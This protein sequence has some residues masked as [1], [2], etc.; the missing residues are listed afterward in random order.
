MKWFNR[1]ISV[2]G[3]I[4]I[5]CSCSSTYRFTVEIRK[6]AEITFPSDVNNV[7][8]VNNAAA[9]SPEES[10][11]CKMM[12]NRVK[13]FKLSK[14]S[15]IWSAVEALA[16][17]IDES[18]FFDKTLVYNFPI[19]KDKEYLTVKPIPQNEIKS[20]VN[21]AGTETLLSVERMLFI[22]KQN[23]NEVTSSYVLTDFEV[24]VSATYSIY[25]PSKS[26]AM[27]TFTIQD[28]L[29]FSDFVYGDS[30][31][32]FKEMGEFFLSEAAR[33]VS[34]RAADYFVPHWETSERFIYTCSTNSRMKDATAL[35]KKDHWEEA[36]GIWEKIYNG[37]NKSANK[38]RLAVNLAVSLEMRDQ[39]EESFT[40]IEKALEHYKTMAN[41]NKNEIQYAEA[42]KSVL[43]ERIKNNTILDMQLDVKK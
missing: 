22:L 17:K 6:P 8:I 38:A 29:K 2:I 11:E 41:K 32:L 16:S 25:I 37:E 15:A 23:I 9:Q 10:V 19:R 43:L 24:Q 27:T 28:S 30:L 26:K 3:S 20:I 31:I 4:F 21:D 12:K 42:Y 18:G 36:S 14:D 7:V 39:Y 35:A 5:F 40:M 33:K 1:L 13:D 34:F